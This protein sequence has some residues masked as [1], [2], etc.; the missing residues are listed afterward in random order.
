MA[1]WP[2]GTQVTS[3]PKLQR[4]K[5]LARATSPSLLFSSGVARGSCR[6]PPWQ[7]GK[8]IKSC[9]IR[10]ATTSPHGDRPA[11]GTRKREDSYGGGGGAH[12]WRSARALR[13]CDPER[14]ALPAVAGRCS[15]LRWRPRRSGLVL[16]GYGC[17]SVPRRLEP[18][19]SSTLSTAD[20]L[21][22]PLHVLREIRSRPGAYC[23]KK[24]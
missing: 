10:V 5:A 6:R 21:H 18:P 3:A 24:L 7:A 20:R 4:D 1:A 17:V 19:V 23:F 2:S 22:C 12:R 13:A 14:R 16:H 9:R 15:A 11:A 8:Q